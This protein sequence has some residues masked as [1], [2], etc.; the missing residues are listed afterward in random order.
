MTARLLLLAVPFV[1]FCVAVFRLGEAWDRRRQVPP[2]LL[3]Y[4]EYREGANR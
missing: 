2:E 1:V 4:R 3:M